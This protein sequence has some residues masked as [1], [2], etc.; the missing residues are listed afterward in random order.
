M[1]SLLCLLLVSVALAQDQPQRRQRCPGGY[2]EGSEAVLGRYWY[3]CHDGTLEPKGCIDARGQRVDLWTTTDAISNDYRFEC[4]LDRSG[5]LQFEY[6]ACLYNGVAHTENQRWNDDKYV[7]ICRKEADHLRMD[8]DGCVDQGREVAINEKVKRGDFL[9]QCKQTVNGTCS[10]CPIGCV[11]NGRELTT[12]ESVEDGQYWYS[13]EKEENRLYMRAGGC[14]NQG[15]RLKDR[16]HF[17]N[18]ENAYECVVE[19]GV[20]KAKVIGCSAMDERGQP[21]EKPFGYSW[22]EANF[23]YTCK[24]DQDRAK[25][26]PTKCAYRTSSGH[27]LVIQPGCYQISD[28]SAIGCINDGA[29]RLRTKTYRLDDVGTSAADGVRY[30]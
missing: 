25:K 4:T 13:C 8:V 15:R 10:M 23:E 22:T 7:Y 21:V 28:G 14:L 19:A 5:F 9:Y 26:V 24:Q 18:N 16:E 1:Q 3:R 27:A 17:V 29:D 6:K 12:G 11:K 20:A 30:C 2:E